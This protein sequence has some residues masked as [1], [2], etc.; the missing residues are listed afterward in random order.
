MK[1]GCTKNGM[2]EVHSV[3]ILNDGKTIFVY[4]WYK[5]QRGNF[6][7][8]TRTIKSEKRIQF[9]NFLN[10]VMVPATTFHSTEGDTLFTYWRRNK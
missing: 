8:T 9:L 4:F 5:S 1:T 10:R 3:D 2:R 7:F 6:A